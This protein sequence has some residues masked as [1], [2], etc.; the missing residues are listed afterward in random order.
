VQKN[1]KDADYIFYLPM[2]SR[3]SAK[4][5]LSITKPALVIFIKYEYWYYFITEIKEHKIP[6]L[7]ASAIFR[8][9]QPFFKWY[10][11]L[12]RYMLQCFTH[13]FLQNK[14]SAKFL[15][16]IGIN[17]FT[18]SG[19][20]RYDRVLAIK[21]KNETLPEIE[22]FCENKKVIV[23]GSTWSE[24][25]E[26]LGHYAHTHPDMRIIVAPHE[27]GE[28][29]F[30]KCR[31]LY[32]NIILY[33]E[34]IKGNI[35]LGAIN[36]LIIDNIGML[37]KLYRYA[38]ICYVGGGFGGDGVHNVLEAAVYGKPVIFGPVYEK[39][40]EAVNLINSGGGFSVEDALELKEELNHLLSDAASYAAASQAAGNYVLQNA[41]ATGKIM[42]YIIFNH[43][44]Q[45]K[46]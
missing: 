4:K 18:I 7:L 20:T 14:L 12:H 19:D 26:V 10:G 39:Y 30:Q 25:D 38:T 15:E 5:F 41:G 29:C 22:Q 28:E 37:S 2:D 8:K 3:P 36:T 21:D 43:I 42:D 34:Y 33:S 1:N 13:F 16:K 11:K 31:K 32:R 24:D 45:N 40:Y 6:L 23:A 27:L 9:E 35:T 17:N 46:Q 44:I